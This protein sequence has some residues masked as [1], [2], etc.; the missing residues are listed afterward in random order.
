MFANAYNILANIQV[1]NWYLG[2]ITG[3]KAFSTESAINKADQTKIR[4]RLLKSGYK[5]IFNA[6]ILSQ[7]I[8]VA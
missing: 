6:G 1:N 5:C 2:N 3:L 4:R 8:K 7:I